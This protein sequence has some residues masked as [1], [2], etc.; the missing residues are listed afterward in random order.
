MPGPVERTFWWV[1]PRAPGWDRS[2]QSP[3][4]RRSA[5]RAGRKGLR[6]TGYC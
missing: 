2:S 5:W 6:C 3:G 1:S 4:C